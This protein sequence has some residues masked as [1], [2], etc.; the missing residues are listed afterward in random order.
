[1]IDMSGSRMEVDE[2]Q[3]NAE[4]CKKADEE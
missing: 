3:A 1:M 4:R 2:G